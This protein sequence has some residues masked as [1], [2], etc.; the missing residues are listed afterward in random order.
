MEANYAQLMTRAQAVMDKATDRPENYM[1]R[2]SHFREAAQVVK[3]LTRTLDTV[4]AQNRSLRQDLALRR[5]EE[6]H[7]NR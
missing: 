4:Y 1:Y 6:A 5:K 7:E 2:V 3:D